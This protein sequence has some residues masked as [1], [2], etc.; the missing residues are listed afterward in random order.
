MPPFSA[1]SLTPPARQ[2]RH[3]LNSVQ[4]QATF[5]ELVGQGFRLELVSGYSVG[6]QD[7]FAANR[8]LIDFVDGFRQSGIKLGV[9]HGMS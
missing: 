3:G 5:D 2:A 7:R 9:T 6:G 4:Y 8:G 1:K